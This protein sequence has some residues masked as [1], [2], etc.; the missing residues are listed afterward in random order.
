MFHLKSKKIILP[1]Y[2]SALAALLSPAL[3]QAEPYGTGDI[4]S[5]RAA[6][7]RAAIA[8]RAEKR[9]Q[10]AEAQ[11][12]AEP[13]HEKAAEEPKPAEDQKEKSAAQ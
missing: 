8:K 4:S 5:K 12:A 10:E 2:L 1:L 13:Q 11:K 9:K 3:T 7:Q 6:E